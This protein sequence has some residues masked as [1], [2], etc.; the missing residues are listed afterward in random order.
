M[1][2]IDGN[3]YVAPNVLLQH[4]AASQISRAQGQHVAADQPKCHARHIANDNVKHID[5]CDNS[6]HDCG[7]EWKSAT[8][9]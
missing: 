7:K 5:Q 1:V 8:Q 6:E 3:V 9:D 4:V 2:P